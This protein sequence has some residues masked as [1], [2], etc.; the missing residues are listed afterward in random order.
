MPES[1]GRHIRGPSGAGFGIGG[2]DR[3]FGRIGV[4]VL[5]KDMGDKAPET[6]AKPH[7]GLKVG[8][9]PG[10]DENQMIEHRLMDGVKI[11][12]V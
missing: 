4:V 12:I 2:N 6:A 1:A 8:F 7:Q 5:L 3:N 9:Q 10:K 11:G